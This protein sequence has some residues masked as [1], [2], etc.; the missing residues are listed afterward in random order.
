MAK[1]QVEYRPI[2][3]RLSLAKKL[4]AIAGREDRTMM[5]VLEEAITDIEE[6]YGESSSP[7]R[8]GR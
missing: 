7:K 2:K 6:K 3:L 5:D 4:K 1:D 8:R